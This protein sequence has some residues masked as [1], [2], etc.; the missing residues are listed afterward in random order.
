MDS[1]G[2]Y[3]SLIVDFIII[4]FMYLQLL[5]YYKICNDFFYVKLN[6]FMYTDIYECTIFYV[7]DRNMYLEWIYHVKFLRST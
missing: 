1:Y 4:T 7:I 6:E 3:P 2:Y 5:L